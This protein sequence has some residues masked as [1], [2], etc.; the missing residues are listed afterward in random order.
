RLR[1]FWR[2][3]LK[4]D[5]PFT[6]EVELTESGVTTSQLGSQSALPWTS[7]LSVVEVADAVEIT[8]QTGGLI[9]VRGRA[10]AS[11]DA[12]HRLAELGKDLRARAAPPPP[13]VPQKAG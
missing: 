2:E 6:C 4:G 8:A 11:P 13:P 7:V 12:K 10:F 1:A 5:G 9:V 3:K